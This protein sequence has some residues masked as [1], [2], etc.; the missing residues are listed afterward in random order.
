MHFPT[1]FRIGKCAALRRER[2]M[3]PK[4]KVK[5][6]GSPPAKA[7]GGKAAKTPESGT[8]NHDTTRR[9]TFSLIMS[10]AKLLKVEVRCV[11]LLVLCAACFK[12]TQP[13]FSWG[14]TRGS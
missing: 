11:E 14:T 9:A 3:P 7:D 5:D 2:Q 1:A 8:R 10:F 6:E 12:L 4:S 13:L